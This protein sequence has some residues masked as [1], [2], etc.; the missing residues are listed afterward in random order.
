MRRWL[1]RQSNLGTVS[2]EYHLADQPVF[3]EWKVRIVAQGQVEE[4]TFLVEEYYQTRFEVLLT[5][6][7]F[8]KNN[9]DIITSLSVTVKWLVNRK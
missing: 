7:P 5:F 2:L 9:I 4:S 3:G 1:S 8:I 6:L